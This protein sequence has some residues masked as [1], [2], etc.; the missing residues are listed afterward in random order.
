MS[1]TNAR[2]GHAAR[3]E[4][5]DRNTTAGKPDWS[6]HG[7]PDSGDHCLV[8]TSTHSI[9]LLRAGSAKA[10]HAARDSA[11]YGFPVGSRDRGAVSSRAERSL[12]AA[13]ALEPLLRLSWLA[14][15]PRSRAI[16]ELA[17]ATKIAAAIRLDA[18]S[19]QSLD[20]HGP[21]R[22]AISRAH[23]HQY[24]QRD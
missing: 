23:P 3:H 14:N 17:A 24:D 10:R 15:C 22:V 6:H 9:S 8:R 18:S 20:V 1:S 11:H 13:Q 2:S 19:D 4:A 7:S 5:A 12:A 16:A 21:R